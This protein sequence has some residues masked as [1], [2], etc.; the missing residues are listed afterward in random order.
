[1]SLINDFTL[2]RI[3]HVMLKFET[4]SDRTQRT[5]MCSLG[6]FCQEHIVILLV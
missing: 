2:S 1:M 4:N 3:Q 6:Y 5:A